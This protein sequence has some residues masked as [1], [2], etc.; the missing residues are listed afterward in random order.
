MAPKRPLS[1]VRTGV[2]VSAFVGAYPAA[3]DAD[4]RLPKR[5]RA[6]TGTV[7]E[8]SGDKKHVWVVVKWRDISAVVAQP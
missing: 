4:H 8:A 6:C 5:R 3:G 2:N 7:M 1:G